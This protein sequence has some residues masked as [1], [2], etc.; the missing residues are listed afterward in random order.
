MVAIL[1]GGGSGF[2]PAA[3]QSAR[4]RVDFARNPARFAIND[5]ARNVPVDK[6]RGFYPR[7]SN[8]NAMRIVSGSDF[9]WPD[10]ADRPRG[11]PA[12]IEWIEYETKRSAYSFEIGNIALEQ[13][14]LGDLVALNG[15]HKT[16]LA[17]TDRTVQAVNAMTD[18]SNF[19]TG[20][21]DT[22]TN[23]GGGVWSGSTAANGH[24]AKTFQNVRDQIIKSTG[25]SIQDQDLAVVIDPST[26]NLIANSPEYQQFVINHPAA[27]SAAESTGI[28]QTYGLLP[29]FKGVR[30]IVEDTA[31]LASRQ[32]NVGDLDAAVSGAGYLLSGGTTTKGKA[33]FLVPP[34]GP[35]GIDGVTDFSTIS[36]LEKS[37]VEMFTKDDPDH[38]RTLGSVSQNMVPEITAGVTG[39]LVTNVDA[40]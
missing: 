10:G 31:V 3:E 30:I 1:P 40:A 36:I 22:A 8:A 15:R 33:V 16:Q 19:P 9:A 11:T 5:Y 17:M 27:I 28:F 39:F 12:E 37:P 7:I 26:A 13:S 4:L 14:E 6:T 23:V 35:E 21:S 24:I 29:R 38:E 34:S 25:G 32:D 20:H 18:S 2:V